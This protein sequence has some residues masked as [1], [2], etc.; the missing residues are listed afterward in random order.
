MKPAIR[1][2]LAHITP[3]VEALG[4]NYPA[5][6]DGDDDVMPSDIELVVG[7]LMGLTCSGAEI[8]EEL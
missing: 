2:I 8:E 3:V 1:E 7:V 6:A 5:P 4:E